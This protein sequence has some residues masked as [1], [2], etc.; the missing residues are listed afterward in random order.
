MYH[1]PK[2]LML[3]GIGP[4]AE[5]ERHGIRAVHALEGVGENLQDHS[6]VYLRLAPLS[7]VMG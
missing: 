4:P 7:D 3:S 2:L 6:V 1:S 5:I